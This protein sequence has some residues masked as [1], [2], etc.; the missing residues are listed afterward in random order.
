MKHGFRPDG[1]KEITAGQ[2]FTPMELERIANCLTILDVPSEDPVIQSL[3]S[4]VRYFRYPLHITVNK[5]TID[6][7][8]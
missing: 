1:G 6:Y 4:E 8:I 3:F 7:Q 5:Q 2:G